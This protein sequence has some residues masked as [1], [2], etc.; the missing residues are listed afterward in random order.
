[1]PDIRH[2]TLAFPC[3][4]PLFPGEIAIGLGSIFPQVNQDRRRILNPARVAHENAHRPPSVV[5]QEIPQIRHELT[6]LGRALERR[7]EA[8]RFGLLDRRSDLRRRAGRA[9]QSPERTFCFE[10]LAVESLK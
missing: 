2:D 7:Y 3:K 10:T 8:R 6:T 5:F 1:M 9:A 4:F